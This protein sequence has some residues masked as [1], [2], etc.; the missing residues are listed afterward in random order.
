MVTGAKFVC[1]WEIGAKITQHGVTYCS[2]AKV[3]NVQVKQSGFP[4]V[5]MVSG[6]EN[7][8]FNVY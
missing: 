7:R 6:T 2:S 5:S 4:A 8:V 3:T 1:N